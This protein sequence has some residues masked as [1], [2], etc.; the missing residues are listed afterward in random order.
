MADSGL[1]LIDV[2]IRPCAYIKDVI[3]GSWSNL[4]A[5]SKEGNGE[6]IHGFKVGFQ[7]QARI[8]KF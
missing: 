3:N 7:W 6:V 4:R 1:H 8:Q 5:G 2:T